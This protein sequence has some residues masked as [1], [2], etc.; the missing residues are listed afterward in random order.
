M[1]VKTLELPMPPG[2][3]PEFT[4]LAEAK[5]ALGE[6]VCVEAINRYYRW[7]EAQQKS[8]KMNYQKNRMLLEAGKKALAELEM[9]RRAVELPSTDLAPNDAEHND[10][11]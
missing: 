11:E 8:R 7:R 3:P 5:K 2:G 10:P 1:M 4:T 6:A 9:Q